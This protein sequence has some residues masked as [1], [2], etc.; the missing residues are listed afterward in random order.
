MKTEGSPAATSSPT[1]RNQ[2]R[3]PNR[4]RTCFDIRP[5]YHLVNQVTQF[6]LIA[7]PAALTVREWLVS[8]ELPKFAVP[9]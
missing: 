3:T 1:R 2:I 5:C 6:F 4:Q 7:V 9:L 8:V